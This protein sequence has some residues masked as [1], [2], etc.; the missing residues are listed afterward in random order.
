[1]FR[2]ILNPEFDYAV[3]LGL[4]CAGVCLSGTRFPAKICR[5]GSVLGKGSVKKSTA[6][7]KKPSADQQTSSSKAAKWTPP[8][9]RPNSFARYEPIP[10]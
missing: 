1:M 10:C 7:S 5:G 4:L 6:G 3:I 2:G 9:C 8:T